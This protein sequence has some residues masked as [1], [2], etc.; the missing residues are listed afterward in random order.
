M[1]AYPRLSTTQKRLT[2]VQVHELAAKIHECMCG[3]L[4]ASEAAF[5]NFGEAAG[6]GH[7][8]EEPVTRGDQGAVHDDMRQGEEAAGVLTRVA[9]GGTHLVLDVLWVR[10]EAAA[11]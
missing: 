4:N 5:D 10:A 1:E 9:E 8:V 6:I 11:Q 2:I 7:G 3:G